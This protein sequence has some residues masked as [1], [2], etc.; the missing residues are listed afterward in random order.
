MT[1]DWLRRFKKIQGLK[2]NNIFSIDESLV[3]K[4]NSI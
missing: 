3:D 2:F 4:E 1:K